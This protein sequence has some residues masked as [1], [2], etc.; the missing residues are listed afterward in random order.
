MI[1]QELKEYIKNNIIPCYREY[2]TSHNDEHILTVIN[3]S[4]EISKDLNVDIDMVYTIAAYHDIGIK[5]VRADH[6]LTSAKYLLDDKNLNRWFNEEQIIIMKQAIEDHRAS[7]KEEPRSIYGRII[8][9]ADRDINPERI[10]QR[11][12][13]YAIARHPYA[14]DNEIISFVKKHIDEKYGENGYLKLWLAT[15]NNIEGLDTIRKWFKN[16]EIDEILRKIINDLV[17]NSFGN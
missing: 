16:N 13:Q 8:S 15:K 14:S 2:E 9:E 17:S 6:H 5:Y 1:N 10:L 4:L 12:I 11:C 3:N 7:S